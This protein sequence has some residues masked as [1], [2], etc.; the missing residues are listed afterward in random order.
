VEIKSGQTFT[1]EMLA[2]LEKWL[3]YAGAEAGPPR[4]IY[5]GD[6]SYE[7]L[8]VRVRSWRAMTTE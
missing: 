1:S 4:L 5:G 7:R 2:G 8:G 6:E 3:G